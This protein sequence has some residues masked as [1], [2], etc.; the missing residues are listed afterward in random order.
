MG[1]KHMAVNPRSGLA[2]RGNEI[3]ARLPDGLCLAVEVGVNLGQLSSYLLGHVPGLTLAMVDN[4]LP[5][6]AQ[7]EHYRETRDLRAFDSEAEC[8]K[9][10]AAARAIEAQYSQRATILKMG[11]VEAASQFD[12]GS[13]DLVFL[14]ADHS[15][16]GVRA[17]IAAWAGKVR[18]GG[19]LSGHDYRSDYPDADFSGVDRAVDEWATATGRVIVQG[20]NTTWFAQI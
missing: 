5:M 7:P 20:Q 14:D 15:Y 6:E 17:D 16:E 4:W 1:S 10:E 11:S 12:D 13:L 18:P 19:W 9:R 2:Q 8:A 3:I